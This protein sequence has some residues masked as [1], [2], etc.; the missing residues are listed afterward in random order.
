MAKT[1]KP[2]ALP[3]IT[4]QSQAEARAMAGSVPVFC[5]FDKLVSPI[6][7]IGNPRNPNKHPDEQIKLLAHII[8]SQ[9]WRAPITVSK[10]SGFVVR[11]HGRLAAALSFGAEVVPVDYQDYGTEAEEWADLIADNRIAELSEIDNNEL[12]ALIA[13]MDNGELP[14]L[15][16]GY[17][18]GSL[19]DL[20]DS[21]SG[22]ENNAD[23]DKFDIDGE[24]DKPVFSK[25]GDIWSL[26]RHKV[27]CGDCT[28]SEAYTALMQDKQANLILTDPPYGID[29]EGAAGKIQNDKFA[30]D[31]KFREFLASAFKAMESHL[32]NDGCI[33]VFHA[34]RKGLPFR[35][36][37]DEAGF[38]V[39]A[40]CNWVKPSFVLGHGDYQY[41]HEP[42]LYGWKK[43]GKHKWFGDRKQ[44]TVWHCDKPSRSEKHPTMKPIPLLGIPISNSTQT[45]GIVLEP[46]GGSGS[47]L[48]CCEQLGRECYAIEIEP[49]FVDVIVNRYIETVGNED[50]VTVLRDGQEIPYSDI[51]RG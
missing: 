9:G 37:F 27:V 31:D 35:Q 30:N 21:L 13:E 32:A 45:N 26:G 14:I 28:S 23:E 10:K 11:G 18:E 50:G 7:I 42:I 44:S 8:Q 16:T 6:D 17:D 4:Y 29:Y 38:Y 51:T 24:L 46:F 47:T 20:I 43:S 15:L 19:Q 41:G 25:T 12:A 5:S 34:D 1:K 48:I 3:P 49:K 39:A 36:A 40:T 2:T 33:Y 22:G